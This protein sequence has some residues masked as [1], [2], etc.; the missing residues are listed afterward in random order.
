[1]A[2]D[3]E[4]ALLAACTPPVRAALAN[5]RLEA[6]ARYSKSKTSNTAVFTSPVL[7]AVVTHTETEG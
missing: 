5:V 2:R 3:V 1:M 7:V 4:A 6:P